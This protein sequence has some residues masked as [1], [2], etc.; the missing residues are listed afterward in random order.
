MTETL[1]SRHRLTSTLRLYVYYKKAF[2]LNFYISYIKSIWKASLSEA[3]F[4][5]AHS[6]YIKKPEAMWKNLITFKSVE[7]ERII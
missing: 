3:F 1:R 6:L 7:L 2:W 5:L 4:V